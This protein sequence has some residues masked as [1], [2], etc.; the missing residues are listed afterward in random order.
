V[1]VA[2]VSRRITIM[3]RGGHEVVL[4]GVEDEEASRLVGRI[5]EFFDQAVP[6]GSTYTGEGTLIRNSEIVGVRSVSEQELS[7][8]VR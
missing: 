8:R 7:R 1:E 4:Q 5:S 2:E 3:M 6:H